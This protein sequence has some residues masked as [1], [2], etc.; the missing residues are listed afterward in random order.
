MKKENQNI[1][2][3]RITKQQL[4]KIYGVDSTTMENW[5]HRY[6]LPMIE[7][8]SHSKFIRP[9]ALLKWE[10]KMTRSK[11]NLISNENK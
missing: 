8:T 3:E 1:K 7:I 4:M 2:L 6:Q 10:D 11:I 5:I 9:E